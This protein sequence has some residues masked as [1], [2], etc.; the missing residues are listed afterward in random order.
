MSR[1]IKPRLSTRLSKL[2]KE[3]KK[4]IDKI[5]QCKSMKDIEGWKKTFSYHSILSKDYDW[6]YCFLL[7]LIEFK[8]KRMSNYFLTHDI[9]VNEHW[10]GKLC[11][12]AINILN[13]GYKTNIVTEYDLNGI[14]VNTRNVHRFM[15]SGQLGFV[16]SHPSLKKCYLPTVREYKAKVLFWK[17]LNHYIE[18][19]WE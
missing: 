2:K 13:A 10:Y 9:L 15:S 8:L 4:L 19:L 14:Y 3:K 1:N 6:D 5:N 7:D 18:R 11:Q 16:I 12:L 17:F